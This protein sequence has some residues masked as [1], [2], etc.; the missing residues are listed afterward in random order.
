MIEE[1]A[2]NQEGVIKKDELT[3]GDTFLLVDPKHQSN[4]QISSIR[5]NFPSS[6]VIFLN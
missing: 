2:I 1:S 4:R 6:I 3:I 5:Q